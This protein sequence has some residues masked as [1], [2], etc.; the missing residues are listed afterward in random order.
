MTSLRHTLM[1]VEKKHIIKALKK[2]KGNMKQAATKLGVSRS[3][4]YMKLDEHQI[5]VEKYRPSAS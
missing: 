4:L 2:T 1:E 3:G 5:K